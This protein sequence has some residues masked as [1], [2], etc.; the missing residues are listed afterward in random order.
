MKTITNTKNR[1]NYVNIKVE[2]KEQAAAIRAVLRS[3]GNAKV[4]PYY[5]AEKTVRVYNSN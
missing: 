4:D 5:E 3:Y 1:N 2:T